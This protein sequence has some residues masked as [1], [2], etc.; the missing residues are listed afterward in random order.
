MSDTNEVLLLKYIQKRLR[1]HNFE[2]IGL[3]ARDNVIIGETT[4]FINKPF[5]YYPRIEILMPYFQGFAEVSQV[6][7]E[8]GWTFQLACYIQYEEEEYKEEAVFKALNFGSRVKNK[9]FTFNFERAI[10]PCP[11][12]MK[13]S[14]VYQQD[15]EHELYDKI[16]NSMFQF[17][18]VV[19]E[20]IN[21]N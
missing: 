21:T 14:P 11:G 15:T 19:D 13:I 6:D 4:D 18:A 7:R 20:N 3:I 17:T 12:F 16:V 2:G 8:A 9:I 10:P 5:D 1:E